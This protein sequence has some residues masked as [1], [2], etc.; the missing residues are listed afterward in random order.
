M[1]DFNLA[2]DEHNQIKMEKQEHHKGHNRLH[3]KKYKNKEKIR[4]S[5][6]F[7]LSFLLSIIIFLTAGV[8]GIYIGVFNESVI[9]NQLNRSNYYEQV[10]KSIESR[11]IS[12][13]L[14]TGLPDSVLD[15]VITLE[16]VYINAKNYIEGNLKGQTVII[17]SKSMSNQFSQNLKNYMQEE[18]IEETEEISKGMEALV[19]SVE[20]EYTRLL[21]F[22]FI[23]YYVKYKAIYKKIMAVTLPI[24]IGVAVIIIA[25]LLKMQRWKHKAVRYIAYADLA[26]SFMLIVMPTILLLSGSYK[27][28][29]I[30]PEYFYIFIMRYLQWDI[31]VFLYLGA[32]GIVLFI[33][34]L[35]IIRYLKQKVF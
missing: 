33:G 7:F 25:T 12:I 28:L 13:L 35:T 29:H 1:A 18:K 30:S 24:L 19:D 10:Q 9:L 6:S 15:D 26:A 4:T 21:E 20:K 16:R 34:L 11:F 5:I 17:N 22:P 8:T 31:T 14:P 2:S 32:L 27:R 3:G 23:N